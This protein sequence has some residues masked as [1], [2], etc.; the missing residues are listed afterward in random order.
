MQEHN[1]PAKE[2]KKASFIQYFDKLAVTRTA[3]WQSTRKHLINF[4]GSKL[5]F[6]NIT[7]EWLRRF[8]EYLQ[9]HI[10]D[11]TVCTYMGVITTCLN[12]A[13]RDKIIAVNPSS[14]IKKVR[15]KEAAPKFLSK[16]QLDNIIANSEGIPSWF[17]DAFLFC[18]NTGLRLSD[19]ETLT[20]GDIYYSKD[21]MGRRLG[22][23]VKEQ[24]KTGETVRIP[25]N[26]DAERI[27]Q[28][29]QSMH[30][31]CDRHAKVFLLKSRTTTKRYIERWRKLTGENF[32]YHSS[33]HTFGTM[34][35]SA[36]VDIN[37]T[38]KLMGHKSI[39]MTLR[40]AKVV[41]RAREDGIEKL[42]RYLN[43]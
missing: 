18:C 28:R 16:E 11:V 31:L 6:G 20:W 43:Q 19:I 12:S 23:I 25:L 1:L 17:T 15:G 35:Q 24:V 13:V 29:Q 2:D 26:A 5:A 14:N 34:L 37:T 3:V 36:G 4:A 38:S 40:Y 22:T 10:Q 33:R 7:E 41:D 8:Q 32:T 39:G 42:N 30:D 9:L 21:R 27:L